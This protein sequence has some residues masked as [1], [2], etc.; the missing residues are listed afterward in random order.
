ML[1]PSLPVIILTFQIQESAVTQIFFTA[2]RTNALSGF[3]KQRLF[4]SLLFKRRDKTIEVF[5]QVGD[6]L[7]EHWQ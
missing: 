2:P 4:F 1:D 3:A 7:P 6:V 5:R